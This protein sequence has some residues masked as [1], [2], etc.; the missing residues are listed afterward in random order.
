[1]IVHPTLQTRKLRWNHTALKTGLECSLA[2]NLVFSISVYAFAW[3]SIAKYHKPGGS[4]NRNLLPRR[5][6]GWECG[7]GRFIVSWSLSP[8]CR[9]SPSHSDPTWCLPGVHSKGFCVYK[10]PSFLWGRYHS[11]TKVHS[12]SLIFKKFFIA[13]LGKDTLWYLERFLIY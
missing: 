13:V 5:S 11:G 4:S 9:C 6:G 1:M 2:T 8:I 12:S 3:V 7:C 10:H